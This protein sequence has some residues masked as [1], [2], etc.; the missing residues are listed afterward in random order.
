MAPKKIYYLNSCGDPSNNPF[1]KTEERV[2]FATLTTTHYDTTAPTSKNEDELLAEVMT[3]MGTTTGMNGGL[4][5]FVEETDKLGGTL[6][7][8]H[9][10]AVN[11]RDDYQNVVFAYYNDVENGDVETILFQKTVLAKPDEVIVPDTMTRLLQHFTTAKNL[12]H[13][14]LYAEGDQFTKKITTWNTMF[15]PFALIPHVMGKNLTPKSVIRILVP[16]T[17]ALGLE[18]PELMDFLLVAC[19]KTVDN[20]PPVTVEDKS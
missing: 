13:V 19:T 5:V 8:L 6:K 17:N 14:G 9:N 20:N 18:L 7:V 10:I 1:G 16:V 11:Q 2:E 3:E 15:L 12:D 4:I